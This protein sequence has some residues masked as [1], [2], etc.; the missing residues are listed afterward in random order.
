MLF[1][2]YL[3]GHWLKCEFCCQSCDVIFRL[4]LLK[5]KNKKRHMIVWITKFYHPVNSG[6]KTDKNCKVVPWLQLGDPKVL[7]ADLER[8][9]T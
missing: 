6:L 2:T 4:K 5:W 1:K 7:T 3:L 8:A 9:L